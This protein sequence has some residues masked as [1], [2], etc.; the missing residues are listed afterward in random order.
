MGERLER[1][2]AGPQGKGGGWGSGGG[3]G[4]ARTPHPDSRRGTGKL[5]P[6]R[7]AVPGAT[8]RG[9]EGD[10]VGVM[11]NLGRWC[12]VHSALQESRDA[13]L[14]TPSACR[15]AP[16][17]RLLSSRPFP[18]HRLCAPSSSHARLLLTD[19]VCMAGAALCSRA[20][21]PTRVAI[22]VRRRGRDARGTPLRL[23]FPRAR[24]PFPE[25]D[26]SASHPRSPNPTRVYFSKVVCTQSEMGEAA[27]GGLWAGPGGHRARRCPKVLGHP[28]PSPEEWE[29]KRSL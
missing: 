1:G 12:R 5:G 28:F 8:C 23:N 6:L 15:G 10:A 2:W 16:V 11:V 9:C 26:P 3:G 22:L 7:A 27:A 20:V 21:F 25:T 17:C 24:T 13:R 18:F 19:H 14:P 29:L 4:C